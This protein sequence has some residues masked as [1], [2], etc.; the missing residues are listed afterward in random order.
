MAS[1]VRRELVAGALTGL[2]SGLAFTWAMLAQGKLSGSATLSGLPAT[3][4]GVALD[5]V[6]GALIGASFGALFRYQPGASAATIGSGVLYGLLWWILGPLTLG[7]LAQGR[8][9]TWSLA[10]AEANFPGL[11]GHLFYGGLTGLLFHALVSLYL[12]RHPAPAEEPPEAPAPSRRVVVLGGGFGGVS[13]AQ[14]LAHHGARD[15]GL[16][17]VLVSQSNYLL[18][19][20]MLAE[21]AS[22]G[23]EPQHISAP[24]RAAA[25]TVRFRRAAVESLDVEARVVRLRASPS[26]PVE[27]IR[28]DHLVLALG[29]VPNFHG[30]PGMQDHCF[31]LKTLDDAQRLRSEER[32]VG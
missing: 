14:S 26:T 11:V 1:L 3:P 5:L 27:E 15:P 4:A 12:R 16:E 22:S 17:I 29:S 10:E 23:L 28:H 19:T 6:L 24:V 7:A 20:P 2:V 8:A 31:T 18:F 21:V 32:R 30:L 25:P 9:P 13:A